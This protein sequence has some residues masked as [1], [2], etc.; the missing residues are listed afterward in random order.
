[1]WQNFFKRSFFTFFLLI[2]CFF[3]PLALASKLAIVIDDIGY[4][5]KEDSAI[6]ALPKEV[7]VAIIPSAPHAL[8]RAE[9]A[10]QQKRDILIHFPMQPK[11][12][13]QAVEKEA[14][15]VGD[16]Y[17][18]A[19]QLL[20]EA[21]AKVPYAIGLN[22][23]MGSAATA[24]LATMQNF[25][26]ALAK[27]KLFFLDSKTG[28]S[29]AAQTAKKLGINTL[30][31]HFFLDDSNVLSDIQQQFDAAIAYARKHGVAVLIGHPRK[32]SVAVLQKGIKNLPSDIQLTGIGSLWRNEKVEPQRA[33]IVIFD[34]EPAPTSVKPF[35]ESSP[36]L[37]GI[38]KE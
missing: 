31:R 37:R 5:Q 26:T 1:M 8:A 12:L 19:V 17:A 29:V 25:M 11:N 27:Q 33:F 13:Q 36:L 7:N 16:S 23:H 14:L 22:N 32:N 21:R 15:R 28:K 10:F 4:S 30:E 2:F 20:N 3:S 9:L 38:P 6:Y 34:I 35:I 18:Q 24:D